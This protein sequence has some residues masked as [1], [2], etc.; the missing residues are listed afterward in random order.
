MIFCFDLDDTLYDESTFVR[1]GFQAVANHLAA[2][3]GVPSDDSLVLMLE[4]L[5]SDGR[6]RVFDT[7]AERLGLT[8]SDLVADCVEAYRNHEPSIVLAPGAGEALGRCGD[9]PRYL[10]TD[11]HPGVQAAKVRALGLEDMFRAVYRT[12]SYGR[13]HAKPSLRCFEMICRAEGRDLRELV[14]VGDDPAKD[15]VGLNAVGALTVRVLTGRHAHLAVPAT[16]D[17]RIL[18]PSIASFEPE[19]ARTWSALGGSG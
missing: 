8:G 15:F 17:G 18:I 1:S 5:E 3:Y 12:W 16:H 6:G 14:Y 13:D 9:D 11:G 2:A 10:V 4:V 19:K 7:V